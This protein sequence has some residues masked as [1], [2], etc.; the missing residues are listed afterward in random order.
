MGS[1]K[2]FQKRPA[3]EGWRALLRRRNTVDGIETG[4]LDLSLGMGLVAARDCW[5]GGARR[6]GGVILGCGS[7]TEREKASD[8]SGRPGLRVSLTGGERERANGGNRRQ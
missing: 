6:E 4:G 7:C 8:E 2:T 1:R 3:E 5:P